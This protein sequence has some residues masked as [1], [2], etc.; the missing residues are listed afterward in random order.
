MQ[1]RKAYKFRLKENKQQRELFARFAG[2]NR[3][4]WNK[5]LGLIKES[6]N[7]EKSY[8]KYKDMAKKLTYWK[9]TKETSF[10]K[11]VH[12]QTYQQTLKDLD[13]AY[14]DAFKKQKGFPQFKKKN[15]HD[16]FRFPQGVKVKGKRVFLPKIGWVSFRKSQ[17]II[18][19]IK[20][21][22]ISKCEN[23]WY[24]SF[25]VEYEIERPIHP[26]NNEIGIDLGVKKF[27]AF[28]DETVIYPINAFKSLQKKLTKEQQKLSRKVKRSS[29]WK[30]QKQKINK[31]HIKI[32]NIR[33]DYLHKLTTD[34][35]KNHAF[36]VLEDLKVSNMS[37][38]A[39]GTTENPGKNIK[40]KSG[41]NRSILD[42][43]WHEF[44]RQLE[45]KLNWKGGYLCLVDPKYTSQKCQECGHIAKENRRSQSIFVCEKCG[46]QKNADIN[47]AKNILAAGHA[48]MVCESN[49]T[50]DRKQKLAGNRKELLHIAI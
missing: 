33:K 11:E 19:K 47:A 46:Y 14:K 37:K 41:V 4:V 43:G 25:Q 24:V 32:A 3:F 20:N 23:H 50:S 26:S 27:A 2:C 28:S 39:R 7:Q 15:I 16:S 6:L 35:S 34:I 36:V 38:S 1:I 48:V 10:L 9:Q 29:N 5:A 12:S 49:H 44:K 31:I 8:I 40:Q 45:Y 42:Q 21:S 13:R 18:G 17:E 22:T 30:K